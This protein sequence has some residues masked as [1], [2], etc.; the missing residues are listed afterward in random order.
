MNNG[1]TSARRLAETLTS[2]NKQFEKEIKEMCIPNTKDLTLN[3]DTFKSMKEDFNSILSRTLGNMTMRGATDATVTLKLSVSLE[4]VA[5]NT[6]E[7]MREVTKPSFKHDISS[8]M[9]VKDKKSGALTGNN[10]LVWDEDK[11]DWVLRE[12]GAQQMN[13]FDD[14][15]T[16]YDADYEEEGDR[17]PAMLL[18][19]PEAEEKDEES[20][21]MTPLK[22]LELFV[23]RTMKVV[24]HENGCTVRTDTNEI[25]LTSTDPESD[26][27]C[28]A[29]ELERHI[30]HSLKCIGVYY[31]RASKEDPEVL[32]YIEIRCNDCFE[33]VY[34]FPKQGGGCGE[35]NCCERECGDTEEPDE[36]DDMEYEEPEELDMI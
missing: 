5:D 26:F 36:T 19:A 4:K 16:Y 31:D 25:V 11:G 18:E 8:V 23:G 32:D 24:K 27:Y 15:N 35:E 12:F 7:E 21:K 1:E 30:G 17:D 20:D 3:S 29:E 6:N 22:W 33:P 28:S 14:D 9:Q 10:E 2:E 13:M 34:Q